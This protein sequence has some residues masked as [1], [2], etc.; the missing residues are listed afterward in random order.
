MVFLPS[1][2][3]FHDTL[4]YC[5]YFPIC[6]NHAGLFCFDLKY[7]TIQTSMAVSSWPLHQWLQLNETV[8]SRLYKME[9]KHF[10]SITYVR[11]MKLLSIN[12][13]FISEI[14]LI[15]LPLLSR[16]I[17]LVTSIEYLV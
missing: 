9:Y 5:H 14:Y 13:T 11:L 15:T 8:Y 6:R 4:Y 2:H 12:T 7:C 17:I 16:D 1:N 10:T 3:V